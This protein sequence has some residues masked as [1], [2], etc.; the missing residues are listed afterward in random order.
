MS[1]M[2]KPFS[3]NECGFI[4]QEGPSVG[5]FYCPECQ[6]PT[7][8]GKHTSLTSKKKKL[9]K[10]KQKQS[11]I[12]LETNKDDFVLAPRSFYPKND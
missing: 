1:I 2:I 4:P 9:R 8:V 12:V 7:L 5:V 3:C 10:K 6:K 11:D